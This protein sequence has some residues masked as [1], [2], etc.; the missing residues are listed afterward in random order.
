MDKEIKYIDVTK[1]WLNK[2][3]PNSHRLKFDN[4]FITDDGIKHPIKGKEKVHQIPRR[5]EEYDMAKWIVNILGGD[6]HLVPRIT[7]ITNTGISTPTPD[8]KWNNEYWDLKTPTSKGQF[9]NVIE[10]FLKK[11]NAR[12][13]AENYIINFIN[14][15]NK[16]NKEI[17][18]IVRKSLNNRNWVKRIIIVRNSS[19]TNIFEK[20]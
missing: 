1:D 6:M 9:K 14:F 2:A 4:F 10:R 15:N 17:I 8:F 18:S 3:I 12:K 11:K 5:G 19:L 7:D 16:S 13:Q 20:K